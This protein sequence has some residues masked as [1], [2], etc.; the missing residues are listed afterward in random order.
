MIYIYIYVC[1]TP[2]PRVTC[3]CVSGFHVIWQ[4]GP[5][6]NINDDNNNDNHMNMNMNTNINTTNDTVTTS[7][8]VLRCYFRIRPVWLHAVN[9]AGRSR[10]QTG[11]PIVCNV[12]N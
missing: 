6:T 1:V 8:V 4:W 3:Q 7:V 5:P 10:K 11:Q 2:P 9:F 12:V